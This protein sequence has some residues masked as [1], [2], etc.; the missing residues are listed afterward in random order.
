MSDILHLILTTTLR[1]RYCFTTEET[2]GLDDLPQVSQPVSV[3]PSLSYQS[4]HGEE[5]PR[6]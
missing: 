4:P 5:Q 2:E 1:D 3:T 6:P